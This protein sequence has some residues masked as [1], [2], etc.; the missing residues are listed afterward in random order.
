[1]AQPSVRK[2][3]IDAI[4][5]FI[6][7]GEATKPV[8]PSERALDDPQ[9]HAKAAAV[10]RAA[11]AEDRN[12]AAGGEALTIWL[13][14]VVT[15]ALQDVAPSARPCQVDRTSTTD[16]S[17]VLKRALKQRRARRCCRHQDEASSYSMASSCRVSKPHCPRVFLARFGHRLADDRDGRAG[18]RS[19]SSTDSSHRSSRTRRGIEEAHR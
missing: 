15:V 3:V 16:P 10:G 1:M 14:I 8:E 17:E 6:A 11:T 4:V 13:R 19:Q 7:N 12:N 2:G 9:E 18:A 5:A